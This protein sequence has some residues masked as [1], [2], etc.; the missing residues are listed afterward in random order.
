MEVL[1]AESG[2]QRTMGRGQSGG[3][4]DGQ[5]AEVGTGGKETE[6]RRSQGEINQKT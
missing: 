6:E 2:G 5:R 3:Q 1:R 4:N